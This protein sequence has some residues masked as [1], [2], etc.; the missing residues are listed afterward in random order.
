MHSSQLILF[1]KLNLVS[2]FAVSFHVSDLQRT[3]LRKLA[4]SSIRNDVIVELVAFRNVD[5]NFCVLAVSNE[6]L[7][8]AAWQISDLDV[9]VFVLHVCEFLDEINIVNV[10][11]WSVFAASHERN[12][13]D[14]A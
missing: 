6:G 1:L 12:S 4:D 14:V 2:L 11:F 7:E 9:P 10:N 5:Q 3:L 8:N 13:Y